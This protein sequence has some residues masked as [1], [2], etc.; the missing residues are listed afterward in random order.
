MTKGEIACY[1][2]FLLFTQCFPQ[3]HTF[4][5]ALCGDE[6]K[7]KLL[8][9]TVEKENMQA[10]IISPSLAIVSTLTITEGIF[11]ATWTL[12]QMTNF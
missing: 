9:H 6:L 8:A 12:S 10:T 2:Q 3:L 5:A 1:K 11:L 7:R 4:S